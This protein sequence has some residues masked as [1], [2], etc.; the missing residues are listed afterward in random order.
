M[1]NIS[2]LGSTGSIG[3]STLKVVSSLPD[4]FS[5]VALTA[6]NNID[7][8]V[9]QAQLYKPKFVAIQ[10][11]EHYPYLK[12]VLPASME[13]AC[14]DDGIEQA[15]T[16]D[17]C[18]LLVSAIVGS[19]G[20]KPT[21]QAIDKGIDIAIATKEVLVVA[22]DLITRHARKKK[23]NLIPIDSEHSALLQ[24]LAGQKKE[25]VDRLILTA[26]GGP[27]LNTPAEQLQTVT[28]DQAL[29]HPR[30]SMGKKI[31]I[32]SA[33][34][35]NKGLELIE[36]MWLFG[37]PAEKISI[38]I[39][40]ESIIH[41]MV[42]YV[43]GSYI[44]QLN[45]TDMTI[46]IQYALTYPERKHSGIAQK[47]PFAE[48]GQ[49]TFRKPDQDKFPCIRLA[50]EAAAV[51]HSMPAVLNAANEQAVSLFLKEKIGFVDIPYIIET[52]MEQH[53]VVEHPDLEQ[54]IDIDRWARDMADTVS[55][56]QSRS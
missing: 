14:G 34:M 13:L 32:D 37:I 21:Y 46:P 31:S 20:L 26:S 53:T 29:A 10:N 43:D 3:T 36:A 9:K 50:Y 12:E 19:A 30:W 24:C 49:L 27:F 45:V 40:P 18:D 39:H 33:S 7:L 11:K 17:E 8:L 28:V 54:L 44:A 5:V 2:I 16:L 35:M 55:R 42:E 4:E 25:W 23:V 56:M 15:A 47:I 6:Q 38:L 41:S 1:K 48:L 52:V 51:G 22:G